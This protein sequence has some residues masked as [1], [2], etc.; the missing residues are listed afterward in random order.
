[1]ACLCFASCDLIED[2]KNRTDKG[3]SDID[4]T[5]T[6][7][8]K[9]SFEESSLE[10][11]LGDSVRLSV[12]A[13]PEVKGVSTTFESSDESVVTV[14]ASGRATA[15]AAGKA[16]ITATYGSVSA[17]CEITVLDLK[18]SLDQDNLALDVMENPTAKLNATVSVEG[19]EVSWES[20][21]TKLATVDQEGNITALDAGT[22]T[23]KAKVGRLTA[24][25]EVTVTV[26][27]G[28]Y[29]FGSA[30]NAK[31]FSN[32]GKFFH[33][34]KETTVLAA[35]FY[36]GE[37][38]LHVERETSGGEFFIRYQPVMEGYTDGDSFIATTTVTSSIAG[39]VR[40]G[41]ASGENTYVYVEAN[42]PTVVTFTTKTYK[43]DSPLSISL[44]SDLPTIPED[45]AA[46]PIDHY[47]TGNFTLKVAPIVATKGIS[48]NASSITIVGLDKTFT[49]VDEVKE[50]MTF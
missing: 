25:C 7:H 28:Y 11:Y 18:I 16:T 35:Y 9:L 19:M 40:L 12:T 33:F 14:S 20:T 46:K 31:A 47:A 42:T 24:E 36:N 8:V 5:D 10:L 3:D 38:T 45:P 22:T 27:E 1:M 34:S 50:G 13:T 32:P 4:T 49:L 29:T 41:G 23:I 2:F 15:V 48:I 26:P 37:A 17:T 44:C 21:T 39:Y 43:T 30:N 6:S